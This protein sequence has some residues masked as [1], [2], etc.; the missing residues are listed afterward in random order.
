M[1][2]T[3]ALCLLLFSLAAWADSPS[4]PGGAT[5]TP[6]QSDDSPDD[7]APPKKATSTTAIG[8]R[9]LIVDRGRAGIDPG[10]NADQY[11]GIRLDGPALPPRA[12]HLPILHGPQRMTWSGFQIK[13]GVPTV[14]VQLTAAPDYAVSV[15][16]GQVVV[17]LKNTTVKLRNNLRPLDVSDFGTQISSIVSR[18][19]GPDT[20]VTISTRDAAAP[21]HRE[22]VQ[23]GAGGFQLL[24]IE[25]PQK[26]IVAPSV[27]P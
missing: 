1:R 9:H 6:D 18:R 4:S 17:R 21:T 12:P 22:R 7:V 15:D 10:M 14:F 24:V 26:E 2:C 8:G 19:A 11:Q 13:D 3:L 20:M 16:R 25:L 27:R 5:L 23:A